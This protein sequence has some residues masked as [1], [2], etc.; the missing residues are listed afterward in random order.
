VCAGAGVRKPAKEGNRGEAGGPFGE[1]AYGD[2]RVADG[3]RARRWRPAAFGVFVGSG[4]S[5]VF[6]GDDA[7]ERGVG[8]GRR[9]VDDLAR[10][11]RSCP[12]A[13]PDAEAIVGA[14]RDAGRRS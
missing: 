6:S 2:F 13:R 10:A 1:R 3:G 14:R 9:R 4:A 7:R 12:G 5:G 11:S 8:L